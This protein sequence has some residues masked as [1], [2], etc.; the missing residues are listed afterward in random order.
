MKGIILAAGEG[1]R[2]APIG[3]DKPK[4]L[5]EFGMFTLLEYIILSLLKVGIDDLV[6]VLGYKHYMVEDVI[7]KYPIRYEVVINKDYS[8]TNTINSL[9]L[10]RN[11]LN[12]DF[13]YFNSDI[14]FDQRILPLLFLRKEST[15]A[16]DVKSC[17]DEE[18]KVIVD[19]EGQITRIGKDIAPSECMGE[20]I[21]IAK[22]SQ[23]VCSSL[24]KSLRRYNEEQGQKDL[25]FEAAVNDIV[26]LH[27]FMAVP[28][29]DLYAVEI[30]TPADYQMAKNLYTIGT[31]SLG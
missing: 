6:V 2:L 3:W 25:F 15:L 18:I 21:G 1:K 13:V 29:G 19:S 7:R 8:N 28:I 31:M 24:I 22:F 27:P 26:K 5:L 30:D 4:C 11:Y 9:W 16:V 17:S 23:S 14:L 10:A 20:F 12:S